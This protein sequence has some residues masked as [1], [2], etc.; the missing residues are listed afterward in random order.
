MQF[1]N[2]YRATW[3]YFGLG[4]ALLS[5][6]MNVVDPPSLAAETGS[7]VPPQPRFNTSL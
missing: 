3:R 4:A 5:T 2:L 6:V 1:G 7:N